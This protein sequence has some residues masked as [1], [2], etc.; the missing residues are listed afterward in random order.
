L[1]TLK[2]IER[3]IQTCGQQLKNDGWRLVILT[4]SKAPELIE[5]DQ[6]VA[7]GFKC[8]KLI[9]NHYIDKLSQDNFFTILH[10][11]YKYACNEGENIN[12]NLTAVGMLQNIADYTA[13]LT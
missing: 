10:A 9:V 11:I 13:K 8:L 5:S 12:N 2:G 1:Q 7:T 3:I 6:I 4:I